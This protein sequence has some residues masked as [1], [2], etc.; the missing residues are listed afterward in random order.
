MRSSREGDFTPL[1]SVSDRATIRTS[2]CG[3]LSMEFDSIAACSR[4]HLNPEEED[5]RELLAALLESSA[6]LLSE[7]AGNSAI[8]ELE[9]SGR[10]RGSGK[11]ENFKS[12]LKASFLI[13]EDLD[14][15]T[16][17]RKFTFRFNAPGYSLR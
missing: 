13:P 8:S 3:E 6:S 1:A 10:A 11:G 17:S 15:E 2:C 4:M 9:L 7:G 5:L 14:G 16:A 12:S